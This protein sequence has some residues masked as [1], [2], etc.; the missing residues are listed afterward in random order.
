VLALIQYW[1]VSYRIQLPAGEYLRALWPALSSS[2]VMCGAVLGM[3]FATH[4]RGPLG[5]M[6]G[7][8]VGV[9]GLAYT[10]MCVTVHRHRLRAFY[11][12]VRRQR[13]A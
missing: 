5:L 11:G 12:V 6:L 3:Q 13:A 1:R 10:L 4:G 8:Q 9:G 7:L 2:I